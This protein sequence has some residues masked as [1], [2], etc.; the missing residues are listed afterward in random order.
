MAWNTGFTR[1][2]STD[3]VEVECSNF[4]KIPRRD[5]A[6]TKVAI[7]DGDLEQGQCVNMVRVPS[8]ARIIDV[9]LNWANGGS[10]APVLAVGD[11][12]AC[13]RFLGPV[14]LLASAHRGQTSPGHC[15]GWGTCGTMT[16]TGRNGD[17]CGKFYSY[18]CET[19]IQIVNLYSE[20]NAAQGGSIGGGIIANY[21]ALGAKFTGGRLVLTV[22][23]LES[24]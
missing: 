22:K 5:R 18:T 20:G 10:T 7:Y 21:G 17:G 4:R 16:K 23:Y 9:D 2:Y 12:Y 3:L 24:S 8:G 1:F 6:I 15:V 11:P 13:G 19:E 14:A